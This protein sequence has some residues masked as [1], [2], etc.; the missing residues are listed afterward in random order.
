MVLRKGMD[1]DLT[2]CCFLLSDISF[3]TDNTLS[4]TIK[5]FRRKDLQGI[6]DFADVFHC[7]NVKSVADKF[8]AFRQI[9]NGK[10]KHESNPT[11]IELGD[12]L[13]RLIYDLKAECHVKDYVEGIIEVL[14]NKDFIDKLENP[15][16][17][18]YWQNSQVIFD[19]Y[20]YKD[21]SWLD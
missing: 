5:Y 17:G 12:T 13:G 1:Y 11:S 8:I 16:S 20:L 10:F 9:P 18:L 7:E 21:L 4:D 2:Y 19:Y 14:N 15:I 3:M 6:Y